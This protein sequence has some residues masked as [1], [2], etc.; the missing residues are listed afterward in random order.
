[1]NLCPMSSHAMLI[2]PTQWC[3]EG[4]GGQTVPGGTLLRGGIFWVNMY[5]VEFDRE[6]TAKN[7]KEWRKYM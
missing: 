6:S 2:L 1:M 5:N 3:S 4:A 7:S